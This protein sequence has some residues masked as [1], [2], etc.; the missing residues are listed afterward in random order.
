VFER[1]LA[2]GS[3]PALQRELRERGVLTRRRLLSSG[4]V[5]GGVPLTN[6]PLVHLLRNRMYCGELNHRDKSYPGEH[7]PIVDQAVFDEVQAKL[8]DNRQGSQSRRQPSDA[9][10]LGKLFDDCGN[11]MTPSY[12]IKGGVRYRYYSSVLAQGRNEEAGSVSRIGSDAIESVVLNAMAAQAPL[13][14]KEEPRTAPASPAASTAPQQPQIDSVK[15]RIDRSVER[16]I[17]SRHSVE[18]RWFDGADVANPL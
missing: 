18:I 10:L 15:D 17:L 1:Y 2:L 6:G 9:L 3:L 13:M 5:R 4:T 14:D 7:Q 8:S 12:A 11:R 16:I